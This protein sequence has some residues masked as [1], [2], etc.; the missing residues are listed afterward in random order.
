[1]ISIVQPSLMDPKERKRQRE[2]DRYAQLSFQQKDDLLKR[3]REARQQNK[4]VAIFV[5]KVQHH[6]QMEPKQFVP[7][8]LQHT[9][10]TWDLTSSSR[11]IHG[12]ENITDFTQTQNCSIPRNKCAHKK[13]LTTEQIEARH[14]SARKRYANLKPEQSQ[15]I[16]ERQRLHYANMTPEQKEAKRDREMKRRALQRNT[17]SRNSIA[18]PNPMSNPSDW[19]P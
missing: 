1:M 11:W 5:I 14:S 12:H 2:R 19:S 6:G 16:C 13:E 18:M 9:P 7:E 4:V 17:P 15:A 3:R 10:T 8:E